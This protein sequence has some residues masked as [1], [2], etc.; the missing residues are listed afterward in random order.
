MENVEDLKQPEDSVKILLLDQVT[1]DN[2]VQLGFSP[3]QAAL[4]ERAAILSTGSS[5]KVDKALLQQVD[6]TRRK[7]AEQGLSVVPGTTVTFSNPEK[8][9][10]TYYDAHWKLPQNMYAPRG[11]R[12]EPTFDIKIV[13]TSITIK[14][15]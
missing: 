1:K 8:P 3:E 6:Q 14:E 9:S 15:L 10:I 7:L 4:I 12:G 5:R 2:L 13:K 11:Q